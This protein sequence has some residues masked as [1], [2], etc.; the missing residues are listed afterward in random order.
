MWGDPLRYL[1]LFLFFL[2]L[3]LVFRFFWKLGR[4]ILKAMGTAAEA[5]SRQGGGTASASVTGRTFRDPVCGTFVSAELSHKLNRGAETF[6]F[7]S[8]ECRR[9]FEAGKPDSARA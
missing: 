7:C 2:F 5:S 4:G 6:H 3:F 1:L 8:P 9:K